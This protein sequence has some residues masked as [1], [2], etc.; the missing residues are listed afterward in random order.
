MPGGDAEKTVGVMTWINGKV[1][2]ERQ[3][4]STVDKCRNPMVNRDPYNGFNFI[5]I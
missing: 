4:V 1:E 3:T 5:P 2:H